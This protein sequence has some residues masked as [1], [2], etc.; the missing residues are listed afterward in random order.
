ML[1]LIKQHSRG[2]RR[3]RLKPFPELR[4]TYEEGEA[5]PAES[6]GAS[7]SLFFVQLARSP[8]GI[9]KLGVHAA[10]VMNDGDR[11]ALHRTLPAPL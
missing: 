1:D 7:T 2:W 3:D 4:F 9:A 8:Y 10:W 5:G 6:W 11:E